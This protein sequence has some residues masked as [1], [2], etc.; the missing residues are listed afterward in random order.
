MSSRLDYYFR[1]KVTES[2]L[3]L[4]FEMLEQA[5]RD[6]ARDIG[7]FGLIEG[8]VASEKAGVP[9][10]SVDVSGPGYAYDQL[11]QRIVLPAA[12]NV[13]LANDLNA[14]PTAVQDPGNEK[15]ISLFVKFDRALSDLR[16]DGNSQQVY[17]RRD[18]SFRFVVR[19]GGEAPA[20]TAAPPPLQSDEILIVDATR[21]YG[22]TQILNANLSPNPDVPG[23]L[24]RRQNFI[25]AHAASVAIDSG[26]F[27]TLD[28][29]TD[30]VQSALQEIDDELTDHFGATARHHAAADID[31]VPHGNVAS[32]DVQSAIGEVIDELA[33]TATPGAG[34]V[35][36]GGGS[37]WLDGTTNPATTVEAQ[38]DKIVSDLSATSGAPKLGAAARTGS[39]NALAAGSVRSQLDALLAH[40]ND[41]ENEASGAHAASAIAYAGGNNWRGGRTN[42]ATTVEA[43][44]DKIISDLAAQTAN[45]DG[46]ERI[47]TQASGAMTAGS[48][49]SQLDNLDGRATT[50]QTTVDDHIADA[51][52]AHAASAISYAG[53]GN[54]LGGRTNPAATVEAQLDKIISDLGATNAND[55]G[56]ERIGAQAAGAMPQGSVRSQLNDLDGRATTAQSTADNHIAAASGA[57]AAT[58]ISYAGGGN[59][60]G[61]RTNPAT[62]VE[63]QLDKIISDLAAQAAN[64]DG[65]ERVGA[66]A[67]GAMPVG[68]VRSQLNN[69]DGR[70]TTAQSTADTAQTTA[71]TAQSTA[72]AAQTTAG[73]A[74]A[75]ADAAQ[76]AASTA[77]TTADNHIADATGAHAA[78]A[79]SYAGGDNWRGGRTNPAASVETQLDKIIT[80]LAAQ[81]AN[82]DGAERIGAQAA[83]GSPNSLTAGSVRSQLNA[84]LGLVN[85]A[86]LVDQANTW[87]QT[88]TFSAEPGVQYPTTS[89]MRLLLYV[90]SSTAPLRIYA[91]AT[92]VWITLNAEWTGTQW[93]ASVAGNYRAAFRM[94]RTAFYFYHQ[95]T[96]PDTWTTWTYGLQ[97]D[98]SATNKEF[99]DVGSSGIRQ[100]AYTGWEG[101]CNG[102]SGAGGPWNYPFRFAATPSTVTFSQTSKFPSGA[103]DTE[104]T[105]WMHNETGGTWFG[106]PGATGTTY[107]SASV[108]AY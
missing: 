53:G 31:F 22:Q 42:P 80:D 15:I 5:D 107:W 10:I 50:A 65:A 100:R 49:R 79:I 67:S 88:Q 40:L 85:L 18:E 92:N 33:A 59:W 56:A 17:F 26:G 47:G 21:S 99:V 89:A 108:T 20:G 38:L 75:T 29:V 35:G 13:S 66:Q 70:V 8:I 103:W 95:S 39:P 27:N 52:G 51:L 90:P 69:V 78:S 25:F 60:L 55:D 2:E 74:Q 101:Y 77:Q 81:N 43:Q 98:L 12:Q 23:D 3:D 71:N 82:D 61:G 30:D 7:I 46:A 34:L 97:L 87:S 86:A 4:G 28:P 84:L 19:Q 94:Y 36:Y 96:D 62:T 44:L 58:A 63:A 41:H 32:T 6:F 45:D 24:G 106:Y 102:T 9:D 57:H 54:W 14:V 1:Q 91:D 83:S 11:G 48:V 68:S 105:L 16:T 104:P 72:D 93:Q 37:S 76:T 64:D 73:T